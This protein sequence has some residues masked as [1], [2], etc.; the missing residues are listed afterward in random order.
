MGLGPRSR[1]DLAHSRTWPC[2]CVIAPPSWWWGRPFTQ[3][4][5]ISVGPTRR[6]P[7]VAKARPPGEGAQAQPPRGCIGP[8]RVHP[9]LPGMG[10]IWVGPLP[11]HGRGS[12]LFS[13]MGPSRWFSV[14][15]RI[16][17]AR[18]PRA[19]AR[20]LALAM[21]ER[22][23]SLGVRLARCLAGLGIRRRLRGKRTPEE[24]RAPDR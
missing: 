22:R 4:I 13:G 3:A 20:G 19:Q 18:M 24:T 5:P 15:E 1:P 10:H 11:A 17:W 6:R 7:Q 12:C 2:L 9:L 14:N 23:K 8:C 16:R 21:A